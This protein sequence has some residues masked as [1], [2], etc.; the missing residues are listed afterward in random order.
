MN[1]KLWKIR[2]SHNFDC[3]FALY[4]GK[5][6]L[7]LFYKFF[8]VV[9]LR[10]YTQNLKSFQGKMKAWQ[11]FFQ[12][13]ISYLIGKINV[14]PSFLLEMTWNFLCKILELQCKQ[15]Y[16]IAIVKFCLYIVR[17]CNQSSVN[18][19]FFKVQTSKFRYSNP[20]GSPRPP[21]GPQEA[22][23]A[24]SPAQELEEGARSAPNF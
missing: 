10:F 20:T 1:I 13:L 16:K 9:V 18:F 12:I 3:N 2:N 6:W 23:R 24:P 7:L 4:R 14:T 15:N 8:C 5:I 22:R 11:W 19:Q 21:A 17:N